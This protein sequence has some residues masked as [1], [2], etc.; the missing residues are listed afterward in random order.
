MMGDAHG[1]QRAFDLTLP[2]FEEMLQRRE[3][4]GDVVFLPDEELQRFR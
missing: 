2:I 1:M 3:I 4:R